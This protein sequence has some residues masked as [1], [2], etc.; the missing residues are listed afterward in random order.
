MMMLWKKKKEPVLLIDPNRK[1]FLTVNS[2]DDKKVKKKTNS[3][4]FFKKHLKTHSQTLFSTFLSVPERKNKTKNQ[5][6]L[7]FSAVE[8]KTQKKSAF[9]STVDFFFV[10]F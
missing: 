7:C 2:F 6:Q 4:F 1:R 5:W 8:K 3:F 9:F 10:F